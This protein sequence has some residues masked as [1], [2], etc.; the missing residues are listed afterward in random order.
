MA[1]FSIGLVQP[2]AERRVFF[3]AAQIRPAARSAALPPQR[4]P[5]TIF[6]GEPG[7]SERVELPSGRV[8]YQYTAKNGG[9]VRPSLDFVA[10][11]REEVKKKTA[12]GILLPD[13]ASDFEKQFIVGEVIAHGPGIYRDYYNSKGQKKEVYEPVSVS[14]GDRV[15]MP[16]G[17]FIQE[18]F[19][20]EK[21]DFIK[22]TNILAVVDKDLKIQHLLRS[23]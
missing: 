7:A 3:G 23:Q 1:A 20:E 15:I 2:L 11:R 14:V 6:C 22:E 19:G 17:F 13:N 18:S 21:I 8:A 4:A 10:V 12:G 16:A 9:K 5:A